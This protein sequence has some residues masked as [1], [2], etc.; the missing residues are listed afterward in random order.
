MSNLAPTRPSAR[1]LAAFCLLIALAPNPASAQ[2]ANEKDQI[3][4]ADN[5]TR[6]RAAQQLVPGK[7]DQ[8]GSFGDCLAHRRLLAET[9]TRQ[10]DQAARTEVVEK[11]HTCFTG[12]RRKLGTRHFRG[13]AFDP[14]IRRMDLED[15]S[16][17][18]PDGLEIVLRMG[19]VGR[20]HFDQ[21]DTG[22]LHD[23]R[24]AE[25]AADLNQFT[26][27]NDRL[28]PGADRVESDQD[29]RGI[30]VHDGGIL[31]S[32]QFAEQFP[33]MAVAFAAP[34]GIEIEFKRSRFA[35]CV[36]GGI[37]RLLRK[38]RPTE[39]GMKHRTRQIEKR[40]KV[41][42]AAVIKPAQQRGDN[43]IRAR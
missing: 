14:V 3:L 41:R 43:T 29:S 25:S 26:P 40:T 17:L 8:I 16:R 34:A 35:H 11:H 42:A 15:Q 6:L 1:V 27:R 36:D 13:K 12:D 33:Q 22:A 2:N 23:V 21:I 5:E 19:A 31:R 28:T 24:H 20:A 38:Q 10:V 30:V 7:G 39:I 32:R 4:A 37:D 18:R 9:I